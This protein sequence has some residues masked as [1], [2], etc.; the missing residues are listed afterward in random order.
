MQRLVADVL[1]YLLDINMSPT[2]YFAS[3]AVV[4]AGIIIRSVELIQSTL[5]FC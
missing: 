3:A 4:T 5:R 1:V 2:S